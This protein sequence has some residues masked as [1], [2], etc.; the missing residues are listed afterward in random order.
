VDAVSL[1]VA[2]KALILYRHARAAR[3]PATAIALVRAHGWDIVSHRHFTPERI[4]RLVASR[5]EREGDTTFDPSEVDELVD[6]Q[7]REPTPAMAASFAALAP[8]HR[9][10]LV[11]M[12]D[13]PPGPVTERELVTAVRRHLRELQAPAPRELIDRLTDHFLRVVE[14][15][16]V[17]W[18]HPSWRD[19]VIEQLATDRNAQQTFLGDC[20]LEGILLSVSTGGGI[21]GERALPLL[22]DDGDWDL[23]SDRIADVLSD[24]DDPATV[25]L[26]TALAEA[27]DVASERQR[28]ELD[29]LAGYVL[30][31]LGRRWNAERQPVPVGVLAVWFELAA[32]LP[33]RVPPPELGPTWVEQLPTM[34]VDISDQSELGRLDDWI[35]LATLLRER[36]PQ[37]V[38][39]FGFPARQADVLTSFLLDAHAC[40][41]T[42]ETPPFR[43]LL[44][45]LVVRVAELAPEHAFLAGLAAERL[46]A[47][48]E[49]SQFEPSPYPP[50]RISKELRA[51]LD[52]PLAAHRSDEELVARVL[53]D[54]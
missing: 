22:L 46:R 48:P 44:I 51:I 27:H 9:A 10:V 45:S 14:P 54:L 41:E 40:A 31:Q 52:A 7:I 17:T 2:E 49:E 33:Q 35:A 23:V 3:L 43:D 36:D 21:A 5:L 4:R 13:T 37:T 8:E 53:R 6:A 30:E 24:L 1:E 25:R 15:A 12:L 39:A 32:Q 11:A 29:A 47:I 19:L 42:E 28:A 20:S 18:V 50:R 38:A 16:S 26:I 34:R